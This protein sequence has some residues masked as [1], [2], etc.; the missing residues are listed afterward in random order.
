VS[1]SALLNAQLKKIVN[2]ISDKSLRK[3]TT[4]LLEHPAFE[5]EGKVYSGMPLEVA[6]PED[7]IITLIQEATSNTLYPLQILHQ[8]CVIL[9]KKSIVGESIVT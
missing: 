3:K 5:I 8:P 1:D 6:P 7:L 2:K 4:D 9:W